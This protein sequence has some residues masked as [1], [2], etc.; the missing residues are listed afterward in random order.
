M[1]T[2]TG[3]RLATALVFLA[4]AAGGARAGDPPFDPAIDLQLFEYA[5]GPKTFFTVADAD[6][7]APKQLS[8]DLLATFLTHPFT[9]YN[10]ADQE[11]EIIDDR[12]EVVTSIFA[13]DLQAAYGLSERLQLG[14]GLPMIFSMTG[15]GLM[16]V[17]AQRDPGGLQATGLGDLRLELKARL[18]NSANLHLAG[19]GGVTVPTSFGTKND[20]LG[21]DL[22]SLRARGA[23]QWTSSDGRL[24]TGANLGVII[25]KP[26]EI[27]ASEV[28]QQLTYGLAAAY[29]VTDRFS[30]VLETFGR[31]GLGGGSLDTSPLEIDGGLRVLATRAISVVVGGGAGVVR[32]IGSPDLRAFVSVGW[33]PDTRDQDHDGVGNDKDRCPLIAEDRDSF[34]DGDGC[35]DDD[36]DGDHREDG[37]DQCPN[38]AEDLDG[39]DDDNGCPEPDNDG[40]RILDLDDKCPNDIEDGRE[41]YQTDGCPASKRDSDDD[42][43]MDDADQ[44]IDDTED[45]DG[46]EDWDG[47]SEADNDKDGVADEDDAC[48]LCP[49][50]RDGQGDADGCPEVDNDADGIVDTADTCPDEA[51]LLNGID[52]FDGCP[53]Q[54]GASIVSFDGDRLTLVRDPTFDRKGPTRAG[55]ILLDAMALTMLRHPE[56]TKWLLAVAAKHQSDADKQAELVRAHLAR[57]GVSADRVDIRAAAGTPKVGAVVIE[58]VEVD[59]DAGPTCPAGT[60]VSPRPQPMA[61]ASSAALAP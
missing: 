6:L 21:D 23:L 12:T 3:A 39:F 9:I 36:N 4:A 46:F 57:R 51:E 50:D 20:Y 60:E 1:R 47:C 55:G 33:A 31:A 8:V 35:P 48:A 59:P 26:R 30:G 28:G 41:P 43:V 19:A 61:P 7:A 25:R 49:E 53:D 29:K 2:R 44:C 58:R 18:W 11:D 10:V 27:Y 54:G 56:V 37:V 42:H 5:L 52:D 24:S 14:V 13:G 45:T 40:D 16:P 32:G 34:Q 15:D 17:T 22:P 38:D